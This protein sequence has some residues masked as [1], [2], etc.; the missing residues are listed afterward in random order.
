VGHRRRIN[1]RLRQSLAAAV[2]NQ[3]RNIAEV[4]AAH[5]VSWHTAHTAFVEQVDP[6]LDQPPEPVRVL[7]IDE[8]RCGKARWNTDPDTGITTQL[9]DRW[10]T[11]FTDLSGDQ[12]ILG[13]TE[14]RARAGVGVGVG[15]GEDRVEHLRVLAVPV[16]DKVLD[17][18]PGVFSRLRTTWTTQAE[19]GAVVAPRMSTRRVACSMAARTYS[20]VPV[21]VT[22]SK[23][24]T[25]M[26]ASA[27]ERRNV[28]QLATPVGR[29][30]RGPLAVQLPFEDA[31]LV[32]PGQDL[33]IFFGILTGCGPWWCIPTLAGVLPPDGRRDLRCGGDRPGSRSQAQ[34]I[35]Q[36]GPGCRRSP[37]QDRTRGGRPMNLSDMVP[38]DDVIEAHHRDDPEFHRLWDTSEFAHQVAVALVRYRAEHDLTQQQLAEQ[39]GVHQPNVA[40]LKAVRTRHS[41]TWSDHRRDRP[42]LHL[43]V[44]GGAVELQQAA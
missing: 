36:G 10:H 4:A 11:G 24:S 22:V 8:I 35:H 30:E 18:V 7:G 32:A 25:A 37:Q 41:R 12:G 6:I 34:G 13:H 3:G 15:V 33:D 21:N 44:P 5:G 16:A 27:C 23:K 19:V 42:D 20:R 39:L 9:A 1:T 26:I 31:V 28:D 17:R 40:R 29:G 38:L 43:R 14:G 2:A